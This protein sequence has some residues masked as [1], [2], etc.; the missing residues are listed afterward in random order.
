MAEQGLSQ[1]EMT[2]QIQIN[3]DQPYMENEVEAC[4]P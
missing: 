3:N 4:L 1:W 2:L